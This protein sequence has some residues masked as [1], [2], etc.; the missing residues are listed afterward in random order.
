MK[1]L[2]TE[3]FIERAIKVHGNKYNYSEVEYINSETKVKIFCNNCHIF[4]EQ[5]AN[6]HLQGQGCPYCVGKHKTSE[7]FI[8]EAIKIHGNNYDYSNVKY[9]HAYKKIKIYCS[10]CHK[11]FYQTPHDHLNGR[12][13]PY[14]KNIKISKKLR[15]SSKEFIKK[16]QEIHGLNKYDYSNVK[17]TT[18]KQQ[19]YIKCNTCERMFLQSPEHHLRGQGCPFCNQSKGELKIKELLEKKNIK[20]EVQKRFKDCKDKRSLPFDFYLPEYNICI[21]FQGKQHYKEGFSFFILIKKN[22]I[23]AKKFFNITKK[24]D[25]IKKDYCKKNNILLLEIK[26][27]DNIEQ[28]LNKII[29]KE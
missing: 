4:F 9:N 2:T 18:A 3:E 11:Y 19:I 10:S 25:K 1:K 14:C 23:E 6:N 21:E 24:H 12:G 22:L 20:Y 13:C 26:Y 29:K 8:Q 17:Y 5:K 27:N 16:A 7:K 15:S 28:K